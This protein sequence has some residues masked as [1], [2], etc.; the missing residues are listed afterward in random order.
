MVDV[1]SRLTD[2]FE[3]LCHEPEA[4]GSGVQERVDVEGC[5]NLVSS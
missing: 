3:E 5:L 4:V 1:E 2:N